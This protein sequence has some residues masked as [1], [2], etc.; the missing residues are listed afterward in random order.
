MATPHFRGVRHHEPDFG[1]FGGTIGAS[2]ARAND[3]HPSASEVPAGR[4]EYDA[5][6]RDRGRCVDRSSCVD[7]EYG[8]A[9]TALTRAP[10][11]R[12]PSL[13]APA[14]RRTRRTTSAVG[15]AADRSG[16]TRARLRQV[17]RSDRPT[18]ANAPHVRATGLPECLH[19]RNYSPSDIADPRAG[20]RPSGCRR[21]G[22]A[23]NGKE[24]GE[25]AKREVLANAHRRE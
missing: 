21:A 25:C 17:G 16:S 15:T 23:R 4:A 11:N 18:G 20:G 22:S 14:R 8:C 24:W 3:F 7:S 2:R 1:G 13:T 6:E 12:G 10:C 19:R 5:A 9:V